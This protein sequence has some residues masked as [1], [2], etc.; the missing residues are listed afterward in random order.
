MAAANGL[1]IC[2]LIKHHLFKSEEAKDSDY[3][4]RMIIHPAI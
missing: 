3:V 2:N 4:K 1:E